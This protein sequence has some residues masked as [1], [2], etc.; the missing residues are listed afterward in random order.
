M[1]DIAMP[2]RLYR[3]LM[4]RAESRNGVVGSFGITDETH[5]LTPFDIH[6]HLLRRERPTSREGAESHPFEVAGERFWWVT[7][8]G[9]ERLSEEVALQGHRVVTPHA[10]MR[11][12]VV[13]AL[14]VLAEAPWAFAMVRTYITSFAQVELVRPEAGQRPVTSCSLPDIPLCVFFSRSALRHVPPL[15]VSTHDSVHL[16]AEN[17]YHE[18]VHQYV[19][20]QIITDAVLLDSYDSRTSPMVDIAWRRKPDGSP[21]QWQVDRVYHAAMVYGHLT[22]W[23]LRALRQVELDEPTRRTVRQAAHDSLAALTDLL[24]ALQRHIDVFSTTG[25]LRVGELIGAA[26]IFNEALAI[27]LHAED[28]SGPDAAPGRPV[29]SGAGHGR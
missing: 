3:P 19:N 29:E 20:H 11:R 14:G 18:A 2:E 7:P 24:G 8:V 15:S 12:A 9:D 28:R 6:D 22:A 27:T 25:A 13:D 5:G 10:L 1:T 4:P 23:R 17:L 16:L 26:Q 21:Q